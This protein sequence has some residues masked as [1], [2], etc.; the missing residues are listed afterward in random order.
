MSVGHNGATIKIVIKVVYVLFIL[1]WFSI[2][3]DATPIITR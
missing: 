2:T 3:L 1:K